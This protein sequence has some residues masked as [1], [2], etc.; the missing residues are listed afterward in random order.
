MLRATDLALRL[1]LV[2]VLDSFDSLD[3][4]D[5]LAMEMM[6]RKLSLKMG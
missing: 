4:V 2:L 5:F 3:S 6:T 1:V